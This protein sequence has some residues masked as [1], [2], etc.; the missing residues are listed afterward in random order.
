MFHLKICTKKEK[1]TI[2]LY[3]TCLQQ[4]QGTNMK[5]SKPRK[6]TNLTQDTSIFQI[7]S[8]D[9]QKGPGRQGDCD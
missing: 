1:M 2:N 7:L 3:Y 8:P 4:E 6:T 5:I 9:C